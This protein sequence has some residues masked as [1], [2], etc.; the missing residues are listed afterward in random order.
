MAA[1][2]TVRRNKTV[3]QDVLSTDRRRILDK[4]Y[5][6]Q[7]IT[8]REY[9]N[10]KDINRENVEGHV[11]GL[12]DKLMDKGEETCQAF[13][14]LLQTDKDIKETFPR[15]EKI[16]WHS[17]CP[18]STCCESNLAYSEATLTYILPRAQKKKEGDLTSKP[19]GLCVIINNE[20]FIYSSSRQGTNKDAQSLAEVF[21]WLG[22]RVLMCKDQTKDQMDQVLRW[23]AKLSDDSQL[24]NVQEW[25]GT[26]FRELQELPQ[27]GDAF[28]CCILSHG[29]T[30]TVTGT[31]GIPLPITDITS[32]F[33]GNNCALL[34]DKPKVF[35]IQACQGRQKH[36]GV[37]VTDLADDLVSIP[38][39]ADFLVAIATVEKY[40]AMRHVVDGS[41]FIQALCRQLK[42]GCLSVMYLILIL[43]VQKEGVCAVPGAVKQMPEARNVTL[44]RSLVFSPCY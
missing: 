39:E 11:I 30:G 31:D 5:E 28:V 20:N 8:Q 42:E 23:F 3:L 44:R 33:N 22:F 40:P 17:T 38:L 27:H 32:T 2:D 16:L 43:L 10:L 25:S 13:L 7:L 1:K 36:Q 14:H 19:T 15:L 4:V 37:L 12:V 18:P 6:N 21:S 29:D 41:W 26:A 24:K 9:N 34:V 35:F